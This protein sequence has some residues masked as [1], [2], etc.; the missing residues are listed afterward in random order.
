MIDIL[1]DTQTGV[2]CSDRKHLSLGVRW[3]LCKNGETLA[4]K[5]QAAVC[6]R[7][8][9][10]ARLHIQCRQPECRRQ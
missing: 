4:M 8:I 7:R 2:H 9:T 1:I 10:S 3:M 5:W 6:E